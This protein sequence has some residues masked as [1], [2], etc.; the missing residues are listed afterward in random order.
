MAPSDALEVVP[1]AGVFLLLEPM[2][3]SAAPLR[4]SPT[5]GFPLEVV[6]D[7]GVFLL[8]EVVPDGGVFLLE[9]VP[10]GFSSYHSVRFACHILARLSS[11]PLWPPQG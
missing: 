10:F 9:V 11:T 1:D 8:L 6:P 7:G 2:S 5:A 3:P 4:L